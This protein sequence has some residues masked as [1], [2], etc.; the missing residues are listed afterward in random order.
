MSVKIGHAVSTENK[1]NG[2]NGKAKPGDQTGA[3]V[4][5]AKWYDRDGRWENVFRA[6]DPAIAEKIADACEKGCRNDN[7]GYNQSHPN[8][9]SLYEE[10]SKVGFDLSKITTP[11]EADCSSFVSVCVN[12]AGVK[13]SKGMYT[14]NEKAV[15]QATKK[16]DTLTSDDYTKHED[17]LKRG[18]I[19][20]GQGHTAI[21]LSNG[22]NA[23]TDETPDT[24]TPEPEN[25]VGN[26]KKYRVTGSYWLRK[27]PG[28]G[29][30]KPR[31]DRLLVCHKGDVIENDGT[32]SVVPTEK[33]AVIWYYTTFRGKTG[34]ISGR[35]LKAL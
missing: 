11:C 3:E 27:T 29:D 13:V 32:T 25:P 19:L 26:T 10:A 33:G 35:G 18:D 2:K 22:K 34:W 4:L 6:K 16:F 20:H 14:G 23:E 9:A 21:V 24:P 17:K 5:I 28:A 12:A 1:D 7:V 15:L 31:D 8:R 30:D